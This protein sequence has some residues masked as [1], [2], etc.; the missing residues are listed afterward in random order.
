MAYWHNPPKTKWYERQLEIE[1]WSNNVF[2]KPCDDKY[3][4]R[5]VSIDK[6]E[7]QIN[8]WL[9][10]KSIGQPYYS[11]LMDCYTAIAEEQLS[12][13]EIYFGCFWAVGG[14][15]GSI[16]HDQQYV[17]LSLQK[18]IPV[19]GSIFIGDDQINIDKWWSRY[20]GDKPLPKN[21]KGVASINP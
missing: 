18:D 15:N 2:P 11:K 19:F 1:V 13:T 8:D 6:F 16:F 9:A 4:V 7:K 12:D 3:T 21:I 20:P 17:V 10:D 5:L 14:K